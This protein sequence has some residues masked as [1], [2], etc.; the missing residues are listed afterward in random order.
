M[1]KKKLT[2]EQRDIV[3]ESFYRKRNGESYTSISKS[4]GLNRRTLF[5]YRDSEEGRQIEKELRQKLINQA[6]EEIMETVIDKANKGSVQHAKLFMQVTGKLKPDGVQ[7][8]QE[9]NVTKEAT[10]DLLA[11]ID[12][13]L[14]EE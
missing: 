3:H 9:L 14:A 5:V 1:S 12:K 7:V 6:Y 2:Q 8:K 11:D 10:P 13:I 4:L